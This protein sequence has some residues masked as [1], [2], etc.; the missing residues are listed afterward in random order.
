MSW[1]PLA[2]LLTV[3]ALAG[4]IAPRHQSPQ[5][6]RENAYRANN[7]GVAM[8]EQFRY[9]EAVSS[10]RQALELHPGLHIAQ[11]NA[12]IALFY[13]GRPDEALNAAQE[14][15]AR[16]PAHP[17]PHYVIG[18]AAR[19]QG[20]VEDASAAFARV[21]RMDPSD[22]GALINLGQIHLQQ[23]RYDQAVRSFETALTA[24][25]FNATAAYGLATALTRSGQSEDAA[26]ATRRFETLRDAPYAITYSQNY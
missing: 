25:A 15:A 12:S 3:S 14:A 10:F 11:L 17:H 26:R 18:L 9:D 22:A 6:G 23:R 1:R 5:D 7:L 16:L 8:L 19:A 24:E 13:A 21:L 2:L 20:R 4:G